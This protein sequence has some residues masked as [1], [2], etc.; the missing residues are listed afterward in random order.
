MGQMRMRPAV[1]GSLDEGQV[2]LFIQ[3]IN[4]FGCE[5]LDGLRQQ[6]GVIRHLDAFGNLRLGFL[7]RMDDRVF[8]L[9]EWPLIGFFCAEDIK[10]FTV[11]T[12]GVKQRA[13]YA[14]TQIGIF[15]FD[16]GGFDRKWRIILRN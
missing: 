8:A 10:T 5:H 11:L 9:D 2:L 14:G 13:I 1:S 7:G 12:G 3:I 4:P 6:V 16:M 15:K